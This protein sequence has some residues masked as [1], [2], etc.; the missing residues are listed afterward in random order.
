VSYELILTQRLDY[1]E[2]HLTKIAAAIGYPYLPMKDAAGVR[3]PPAVLE[4]VDAGKRVQ[5]IK[6]Y[7][8]LT[9][10]GLAEAKAVVDKLG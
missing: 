10:L 5:A 9:G 4:L 2:E 6:L 8:E 3:I 1:I 7:R